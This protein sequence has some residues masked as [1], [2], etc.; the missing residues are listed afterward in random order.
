MFS[1]TISQNFVNRPNYRYNSKKN[2]N[3]K[4]IIEKNK[5]SLKS[6][7]YHNDKKSKKHIKTKDN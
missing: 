2:R 7:W 5:Q 3:N 6:K 1:I 4:Q